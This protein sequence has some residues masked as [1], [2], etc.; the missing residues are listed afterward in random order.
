MIQLTKYPS[1]IYLLGQHHRQLNCGI[2]LSYDLYNYKFESPT[3]S[4]SSHFCYQ[5]YSQYILDRNSNKAIEKANN[6]GG[7]VSIYELLYSSKD[8]LLD[9]TYFDNYL[10]P[11]I[12]LYY[13]TKEYKTIHTE[14]EGNMS[15]DGLLSAATDTL[16]NK[17]I[18]DF[19]KICDDYN[20]YYGFH[21]KDD[22]SNKMAGAYSS[23]RLVGT[24]L[25][26]VIAEPE[27]HEEIKKEKISVNFK[28][29]FYGRTTKYI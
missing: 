13:T 7:I 22:F 26:L 23:T 19:G 27:V 21:D 9:Q 1:T 6:E 8:P 29:D 3:Q 16:E 12:G 10:L 20:K 25:R 24:N 4:Q 2:F 11:Y 5:A 15:C 28:V 18:K 14:S 17:N